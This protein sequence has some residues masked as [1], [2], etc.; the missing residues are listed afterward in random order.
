MLYLGAIQFR[1][2]SEFVSEGAFSGLLAWNNEGLHNTIKIS[3]KQ[4]KNVSLQFLAANFS[5]SGNYFKMSNFRHYY[6][7]II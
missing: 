4:S 7:L 2:K 6:C 5:K 3:S 1:L